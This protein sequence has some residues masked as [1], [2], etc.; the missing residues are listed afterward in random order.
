LP[1][2]L[3]ALLATACAVSCSAG[4]PPVGDVNVAPAGNDAWSGRLA[5]PNADKTDGPVASLVGAR[6]A[7][8][9]LK[10]A[11]EAPGPVTIVIQDGTYRLTEPVVFGPEDG[12]TAAAPVVYRAAE[13]ARPVFSGG[14]PI[15]GFRVRDD[16]TW[17]APV[18][19]AGVGKD[20]WTFVQLFV[21]GRRAVRARSPNR[22]Y[23]YT[24]GKVFHA[25]D[26]ETGKPIDASRRAFRARPDDIKPLLDLPAADLHEV[27]L[28]P[29][30]S[31]STSLM[32]VAAVDGKTNTVI[33]MG[34]SSWPFMKWEPAQRYHLE[35][36]EAA[37]D[38]PGEWFLRRDGTLLYRP[39][40]GED[41]GACEVVAPVTERLVLLA[42]KPDEGAFV[43]HLA[44]RGLVFEHG[45]YVLPPGGASSV[46]A[47]AHVGATIEADGARHVA[48]EN[49][50]VRHVGR[51]AFWFR[52]GCR[53]CRV[54]R[55]HMHDL[56]CGGVRIGPTRWNRPPTEADHTTHIT[57]HNCII[58]HGGRL[59]REA[60]GVLIGHSGDNTVTHNEIADFF[61]TGVS[62]GWSWG[63]RESLA[64]RNTID[65]NHIHHIGWGVLSDMGAVY[66][67]GVSPGTTVSSNRCHDIYSYSYG[68]WGLYTDEGSSGIVM[69]NNL[70]HHTKTGGFHQHY[71]RENVIRNNIFA[72]AR[73]HQLQRSRVEDHLSFIFTRNIVYWSTGN[74]LDRH[75][76]DKNV[77][78]HHNC[79]WN[80]SGP[81][82]FQGMTLE[83]WQK[84]TGHSAGSIVADPKFRDAER[85]DY[86]LTDDS[87]ALAV[88]FK[89]FDYTKAGVYGDAD[90]VAL[91][92][93]ETYPPLQI[94]AE[95]PPA[96]PLEFTD[97]FET[98]PLGRPPLGIQAMHVEGKGDG[99]GVTEEA[100]AT[101][102]RSL[103]VTD[104][105]GL[106]HNWN[107]H[108]YYRPSHTGGTTTLAFA[109]RTAPETTMFV[110]W[111]SDGH[112]YGVGPS[113]WLQE[114]RV[115]SGGRHLMDVPANAWVRIRM[116]AGLGAQADG[117]WDL[118]VTLPGG[119]T[120]T[121]PDLP[122]GKAGWKTLFWL[123][124][125]SL[126]TTETAFYLDDVRL[127]HE[128]AGP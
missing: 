107:P 92:E 78:M 68:G 14:R 119:E 47:A 76:K 2:F 97:G 27:V 58:R 24:A 55:T 7:V 38:A 32:R 37:L 70:V 122:V 103:K 79:Y 85:G 123:G 9:R 88:G 10:K 109:I 80:T 57:V 30:H 115:R 100:A 81:A 16:G 17:V 64:V 69:E 53:E 127:E 77:R 20:K 111:R 99:I 120:K 65:F 113:L 52:H 93:G 90:W 50:E 31:W 4:T 13:G 108:F 128:P 19:G 18:P 112:P 1:V 125:C 29:Y 43:E 39:R 84:E 114:G 110:E 56:G 61:Y 8:R 126:N 87:P 96:P 5:A 121:F 86:R 98:T 72:F 104:A 94:A 25:T 28:V 45:G 12:G 62:V 82:E 33:T 36:Y 11:R 63:Y 35:N 105:A 124:F 22:W 49:C 117:T 48:F 91:A 75:W 59:Y 3:T 67:L 34:R 106:V 71:G 54:E 101:G 83:A 116:T 40:E 26:P 21:S 60:V 41:P 15:T 44:F 46:Q 74:V 118:A 89:P 23:H 102:K 42:G 73:E 66:T 95:P 6:D 51:Y